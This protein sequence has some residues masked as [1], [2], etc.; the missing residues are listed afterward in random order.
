MQGM[1]S[2]HCDGTVYHSACGA[3]T[4]CDGSA[5]VTE[6]KK[7][8]PIRGSP[9]DPDERYTP[10]RVSPNVTD[11]NTLICSRLTSAVGQ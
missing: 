4:P 10:Y 3:S 7:G 9:G 5:T 6:T 2:H 11:R 8:S 1:G